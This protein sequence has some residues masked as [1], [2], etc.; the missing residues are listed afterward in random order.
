MNESESTNLTLPPYPEPFFEW[1]D[2]Q[3]KNFKYDGDTEDIGK[4]MAHKL[5]STWLLWTDLRTNDRLMEI[6]NQA[7]D[8]E[9]D[10]FYMK[11]LLVTLIDRVAKVLSNTDLT[12]E[13]LK[14]H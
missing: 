8:K 13:L 12:E 4:R 1:N 14:S 11:N 9:S 2:E 6:V 10:E 7:T 5:N 3:I